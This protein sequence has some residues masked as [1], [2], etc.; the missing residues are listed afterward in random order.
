M[1]QRQAGAQFVRKPDA[2]MIRRV[3]EQ[4]VC[5]AML[6]AGAEA[7][8]QLARD[9][10]LREND[11]FVADIVS[12]VFGAMRAQQVLLTEQ[13]SQGAGKDSKSLA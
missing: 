13:I 1:S 8:L 10:E 5:S 9:P 6:L 2:A 11:S 7:Y 12:A 3:Q 4:E